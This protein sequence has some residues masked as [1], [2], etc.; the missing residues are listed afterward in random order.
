MRSD[1]LYSNSADSN[2]KID[3]TYFTIARRLKH[4]RTCKNM[5]QVT[6]AEKIG[7]SSTSISGYEKPYCEIPIVNL[8]KIADVFGLEISYFTDESVPDDVAVRMYQ[9][10]TCKQV[11]SY[12][13]HTNI[14]GIL[15]NDCQIADGCVTLPKTMTEGTNVI[16]TDIPDNSLLNLQYKQGEIIFVDLNAKPSSGSVALLYDSAKNKMIL[17]KYIH[18]GPM[19]T[20]ISDGHGDNT[21]IYIDITDSDYAVVGPVIRSTR[22]C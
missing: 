4:I 15:L 5:T 2:K 18:D 22:D 13:K 21:P 19:A 10:M 20:L 12:Y 3:S 14:N 7:V 6:L 17:R 16:C 8:H 1:Y 11:I 9:R